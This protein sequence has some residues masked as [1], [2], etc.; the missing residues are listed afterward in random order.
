MLCEG[1][2]EYTI[3]CGTGALVR[4]K[5]VLVCSECGNVMVFNECGVRPA[6]VGTTHIS[7]VNYCPH[8]GC[9][10]TVDE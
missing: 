3:P 7:E 1:K 10:G 8:C 9:K 5:R 4:V 6:L 2:M